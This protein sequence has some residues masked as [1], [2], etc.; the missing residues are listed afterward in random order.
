MDN[1]FLRAFRDPSS[2][3]ILGKRVF[4][5]CLKHR[6]RLLSI[7]SPLVTTT[8]Q[9]ITPRDLLIAVK[10][11]AE[12]SDLRVGFWDEVR[13]RVFQYQPEKFAVEVARFVAHCHLDAWPKYWDAPKSTDS[14]DG[15]GI[16]WPLMIVTNLVANGIDEQRAWEMPEAQAI[17]LSTAFSTRA[18]A[19]V[20]LLTTEEEEM[21]EA[22]RRGEL[23]TKQG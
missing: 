13:L 12:E 4:P 6:V 7:E 14:A 8:E 10:V 9:G 2:R 19:K 15:V 16:P 5:F 3:V 17:W 20:N 22:I 1:R 23:P 18:G 11:C 21:M